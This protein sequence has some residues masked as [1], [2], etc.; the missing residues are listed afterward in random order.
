MKQIKLGSDHS[1]IIDDVDFQRVSKFKWFPSKGR[2][3]TY[4]IGKVKRRGGIIETVRMHQFIIGKK[5]G[6]WID[7]I[8]GNGLNNSRSNLRRCSPKQN[9]GNSNMKS[10]NTSGFKGVSWDSKR[11]KW[12]A[13][14]A[15]NYKTIH[16]GRFSEK[17]D[18]ANAYDI[19]AK[20]HFGRFAR[21]N[22]MIH[23]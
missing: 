21:M 1:T 7:H 15:I 9:E 4:A 6:K 23:A 17:L 16:L 3:T 13:C 12:A 19:A 14:I 20:K 2:G 10:T 5:R 22:K 18:A 11:Y 8:D